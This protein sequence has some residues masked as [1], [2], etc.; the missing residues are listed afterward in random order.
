MTLASIPPRSFPLLDRNGRRSDFLLFLTLWERSP[1]VVVEPTTPI[2]MNHLVQVFRLILQQAPNQA[3]ADPAVP[4][5][6][7][8]FAIC[9]PHRKN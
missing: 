9:H 1:G 6:S 4:L 3:D 8:A 2:P 5:P 7:G